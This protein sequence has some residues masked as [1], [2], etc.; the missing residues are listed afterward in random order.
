MMMMMIIRIRNRNHIL[1]RRVRHPPPNTP[2]PSLLQQ[3]LLSRRWRRLHL[4][5]LQRRHAHAIP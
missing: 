3:R 1:I 2:I 4:R 5:V